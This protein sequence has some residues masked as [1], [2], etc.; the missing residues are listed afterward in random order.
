MDD[1]WEFPEPVDLTNINRSTQLQNRETRQELIAKGRRLISL[2]GWA[3]NPDRL[4]TRY[5]DPAPGWELHK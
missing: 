1:K 3:Y 4:A 5:I 2:A